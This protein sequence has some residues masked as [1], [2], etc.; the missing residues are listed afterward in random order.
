MSVSSADAVFLARNLGGSDHGLVDGFC[1]SCVT[2]YFLVSRSCGW[3]KR[4]LPV[5]DE[6]KKTYEGKQVHLTVVYGR[7]QPD[8]HAQFNVQS[9]PTIVFRSPLDGKWRQYTGERTAE[10]MYSTFT[11]Y[12]KTTR[13]VHPT[14]K[15]TSYRIVKA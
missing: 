7:D 10:A 11:H 9:V 12:L 13:I 2:V 5:I 15:L 4:L 14:V 6:M 1:N 3:C 8:V